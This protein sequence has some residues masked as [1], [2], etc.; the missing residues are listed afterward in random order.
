[1]PERRH[2]ACKLK[3]TNAE[4]DI[5]YLHNLIEAEHMGRMY[6]SSGPNEVLFLRPSRVAFHHI[7]I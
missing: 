1:M 4:S 2:T 7:G 6:N 3:T 5:N